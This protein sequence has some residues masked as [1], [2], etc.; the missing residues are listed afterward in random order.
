MVTKSKAPASD[1]GAVNMYTD[2]GSVP[3]PH[4]HTLTLTPTVLADLHKGKN[5]T[6]VSGTA[7]Q[8]CLS[9]KT[10]DAVF[11]QN[12]VYCFVELFRVI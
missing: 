12:G 2:V 5:V 9:C 3:Y 7:T 6:V 4:D 11:A 1:H 8:G 10:S